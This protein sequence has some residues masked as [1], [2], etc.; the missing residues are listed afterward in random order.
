MNHTLFPTH[1][2]IVFEERVHQLQQHTISVPYRGVGGATR[3]L[4]WR[5][6]PPASTTIDKCVED[7]RLVWWNR[8]IQPTQLQSPLAYIG[9]LQ[10]EV[11]KHISINISIWKYM[12]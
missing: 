1:M 8:E 10:Y 5:A 6:A 11:I 7:D 9:M 4:Q 12:L 2:H 3:Q